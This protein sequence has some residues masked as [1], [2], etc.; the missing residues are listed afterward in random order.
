MEG[1]LDRAFIERH[2]IVLFDGYCNL[3]TRSVQFI[4]PRD[5]KGQFYFLS[6]QDDKADKLFALLG[7]PK[8]AVD[9]VVV[10]DKGKVAT[11]SSAALHIAARL[12]GGWP[13]FTIFWII[14]KFIRD[15]VY[16]WIARNRYRWFGQKETCWL[17]QPEWK[18]RFL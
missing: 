12:T 13:L 17:P 15:A 14:P 1:R 3:C 6:L 18:A 4:L 2:A 7:R 9:S 11:R 8:P 16:D 10:V 5:R